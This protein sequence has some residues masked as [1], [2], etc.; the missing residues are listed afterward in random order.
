M[1]PQRM[2]PEVARRLSLAEQH[3]WFLK[4]RSR[5]SLLRGG[6]VATGATLGGAKLLD[7]SVGS[8]A[9]ASS[10]SKTYEPFNT[11]VR[12]SVKNGNWNHGS[13]VVPLGGHISFGADPTS[14][15]NIAW[16]VASS[17]NDPFPDRDP[18]IRPRRTHRRRN[19]SVDY[20][21]GRYHSLSGQRPSCAVS[22]QSC[23][24][25]VLLACGRYP[26]SPWDHLLLLRGAPRL[27]FTE[28]AR[29]IWHFHDGTKLGSTFHLQHVRRSGCHLRRGRDD[30]PH[31]RAEPC[32]PSSRRRRLLCRERG[33]W[34]HHRPVRPEGVGLLLCRDRGD[35]HTDSL[36]GVV[37]NHEMEAWHSPDGYGGDIDR[38][39]FPGNGPSICPGTYYFTYGNAAFISLDPNDVSY[40]I[41]ANFGY[42]G[43]QQT[44]WLGSTLAALRSDPSVD[45]IVVFFHH[46]A[47]APAGTTGAR[48]GYSNSGLLFSTNTRS[49]W[50]STVTTTSTSGQT[51]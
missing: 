16:Q 14:A 48:E 47:F 40:E 3:E 8:T 15:M 20:P 5:R 41:P 13:T 36:D 44:A 51:R 21:V 28:P 25:A 39:D 22:C 35:R 45:F 4:Q 2:T 33:E 27:R 46:C 37:G 7:G 24:R 10:R 49:T 17:V 11:F 38:L 43:G 31:P 34:A 29:T 30:Q 1:G 32:I 9:L 19:P 12:S 42:S 23:R 50:S 6:L 18:S 26:A